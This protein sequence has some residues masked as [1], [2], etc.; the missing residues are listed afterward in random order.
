MTQTTARD[1]R[2]LIRPL[3]GDLKR[4]LRQLVRTNSVAVPPGGD[5]TPAQQVLQS[6]FHDHG[7]RAQLYATEFIERSGNP[8]VRKNRSYRGRKNLTT[9]FSGTGR[10]KS[11]LLNAHMDTVPAG[12]TPWSRSPWSGAYQGGRVH[13]LGS[14]DMKGG[15]VA[16]AAVICALKKAGIRTGG[17]ILFESVVDEEWGG[18]GGTIAARIRDGGA[19]ACV[20]PE[21]T[22][23]DIY[24]ATRGGFVVDL[25]V[26]AGD[27]SAYFSDAEVVSPVV[28]F[29]RLLRWVE[30]CTKK[31]ARIRSRGAYA[32]FSDPVPVQLLAMQANQLDPE[33]P[34]S[35]PSRA[36]MRVYF[37]FLPEED[38][39][40]VIHGIQDSLKQFEANDPFFRKYP[41]QWT[42]LNGSPLLGHELPADH[43]WTRCMTESAAT[44]LERKPAV[45]AAPYPCD[46][47]LMQRDFGIPTLLFGPRG[48][49]A[50]N[51]DEYVEFD[52][53]LRTAE[54]L[55]AAALTW[56]NG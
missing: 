11:L 41:I 26:D 9:R 13:G 37:Q 34:L 4:L 56:T 43:A 54:V 8:L 19:D 10:G 48:A 29:G 25:S 53:V 39:A 33:I 15:L 22:Q 32:A 47:G 28:P 51:P 2:R 18:G 20:I 16:N 27:P 31:R 55:L 12:K 14:F 1:V 44:V 23:L 7:V 6:F 49:G 38:V 21:G 36:T 45:T 17:D 40:A 46:A 52:S 42:P 24:R 30:T 35:V 3:Q 50:H 5:E